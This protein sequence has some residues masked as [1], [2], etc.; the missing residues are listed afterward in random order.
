MR[1]WRDHYLYRSKAKGQTASH[2]SSGVCLCVPTTIHIEC[3]DG[4]TF[5][6]TGGTFIL[7][8]NAFKNWI[9]SKNF[10][11]RMLSILDG[12]TWETLHPGSFHFWYIWYMAAKN[13]KKCTWWTLLHRVQFSKMTIDYDWKQQM[14]RHSSDSWKRSTAF[15]VTENKNVPDYRR[16]IARL[17]LVD[18]VRKSQT[19]D[20]T[21]GTKLS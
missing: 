12:F 4:L 14:T 1:R 6:W 18:I 8:E 16:F 11:T 13:W 7:V 17:L 3:R 15:S 19:L 5:F 21:A 20:L 10:L 2:H 9:I